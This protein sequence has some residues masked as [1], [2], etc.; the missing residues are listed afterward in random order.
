MTDEFGKEMEEIA[1]RGATGRVSGIDDV[2]KAMVA[3]HNDAIRAAAANQEELRIQREELRAAAEEVAT[4]LIAY[5]DRMG[6]KLDRHIEE[7]KIALD[8]IVS[9]L[10]SEDGHTGDAIRELATSRGMD[11]KKAKAE[12]LA[13]VEGRLAARAPR[14][15][16]DPPDVDFSL[17]KKNE[18]WYSYKIVKWVLA[19]L[20]MVSLGWGVTFWANSCAESSAQQQETHLTASPSPTE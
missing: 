9:H 19:G 11:I 3:A 15:A 5:N 16:G 13:E 12:V 17:D 14:R 1:I 6:A 8:R 7:D 20:V 18:M 10:E 2:L 4:K